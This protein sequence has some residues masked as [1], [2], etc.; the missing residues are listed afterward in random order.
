MEG[1]QEGR[2]ANGEKSVINP[3]INSFVWEREQAKESQRKKNINCG[4]GTVSRTCELVPQERGP[5]N[6]AG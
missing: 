3:G 5:A 2:Q 1:R 4:F 6:T